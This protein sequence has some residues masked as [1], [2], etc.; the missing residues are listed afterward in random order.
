[1]PSSVEGIVDISLL[2]SP[3]GSTYE[4]RK[5]EYRSH[6]YRNSALVS[7]V[8]VKPAYWM[9]VDLIWLELLPSFASSSSD[10]CLLSGVSQKLL[11]LRACICMR[12]PKVQHKFEG[13][14]CLKNI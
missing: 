5:E 4:E 14:F 13:E 2:R 6:T 10:F 8:R 12:T 1:M 7:I 3:L 9:V 11:H